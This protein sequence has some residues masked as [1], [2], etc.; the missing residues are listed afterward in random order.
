MYGRTNIFVRFSCC[1]AP[2]IGKR[3]YAPQFN[4]NIRVCIPGADAIRLARWYRRGGVVPAGTAHRGYGWRGSSMSVSH[5]YSGSGCLSSSALEVAIASLE[6]EIISLV[7]HT[8][9]EQRVINSDDFVL[10]ARSLRSI[11]ATLT[12]GPLAA[13]PCGSVGFSCRHGSEAGWRFT[14]S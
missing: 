4:R 11:S 1:L 13:S 6:Y 7:T 10:A 8:I 14:S 9:C 12:P 5:R 2:W 3:C